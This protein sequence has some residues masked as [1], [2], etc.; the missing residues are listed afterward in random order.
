MEI[1]ALGPGICPF[2]AVIQS[3]LD[4]SV[5]VQVTLKT[6][7]TCRVYGD[8]LNL[9]WNL[10]PREQQQAVKAFAAKYGWIVRLHEPGAYG[11]VADFEMIGHGSQGEE[12]RA[13]A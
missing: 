12:V 4:L 13:A 9:C 11:M 3:P 7:K 1:L 10:P 5:F 2:C 6:E 8:L